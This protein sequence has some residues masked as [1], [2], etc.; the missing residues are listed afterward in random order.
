MKRWSC[1]YLQK[2]VYLAPNEIRACC[3]RF[4]IDG[5]LKG[6]VPLITLDKPRPVSYGEVI[7]AKKRLIANINNGSDRLCSGCPQLEEFDW[8]D[9]E[10]EKLN[11]ISIENNSVCNMR[12]R[13]C[14]ET[15]YGG[16]EPQYSLE[17]LLSGVPGVEADLHIAWGGGEPTI[18][19]DFELLLEAITE[20]FRPKTQRIFTNAL[21]YSCAL[22]RAVDGGRAAVTVSIDA[23]TEPVFRMVRG[24]EGLSKVLTNLQKYSSERSDLVTIKYIFTDDNSGIQEIEQF[25]ESVTRY[26]LDKCHFL[27]STDFKSQAISRDKMEGIIAMYFLLS[28]KGVL[29]VNFDDHIYNKLRSI[30]D[31]TLKG[32]GQSDSNGSIIRGQ[33]QGFW[34]TVRR[35]EANDLVVWGTGQFARYLLATSSKIRSGEVRL[36]GVVDGNQDRVGMEFMGRIVESPDLLLRNTASI[37]IASSNYYGEIVNKILLM[38][39]PASRIAPNFIL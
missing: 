36:V 38:G 27:I 7:E 18:R 29:V 16:V 19:K 3:Q 17:V 37:V 1:V 4:F 26:E 30:G 14:S 10:K 15:Y 21:K 23:G 32:A 28:Q 33:V 13:Y 2:A 34:D 9:P 6:D 5:V 12:C 22:Q 11:V 35:H 20:R 24:V 25:V 39:I 31:L 8:E